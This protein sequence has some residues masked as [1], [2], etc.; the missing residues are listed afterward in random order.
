MGNVLGVIRTDHT[1]RGDCTDMI[2]RFGESSHEGSVESI[3]NATTP[4]L[5]AGGSI[6]L[7]LGSGFKVE[8]SLTQMLKIASHAFDPVSSR[9]TVLSVYL[10]L[11]MECFGFG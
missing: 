5:K 8:I 9:R 10:A 1:A 3:V 11:M 2:I 6:N 4:V 7:G